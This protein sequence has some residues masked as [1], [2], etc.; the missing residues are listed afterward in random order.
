[1]TGSI[2]GYWEQLGVCWG[3]N[4]I[5]L[6][7]TGLILESYWEELGIIILEVTGTILGVGKNLWDHAGITVV[8]YWK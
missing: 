8:S 3:T 5:I 4:G 6:S 2:L 1:M 7:V